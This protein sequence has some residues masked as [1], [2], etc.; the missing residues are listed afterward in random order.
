MKGSRILMPKHTIKVNGELIDCAHNQ[1]ISLL[2]QLEQV[3]YRIPRGCGIGCCGV[4][5]L[6]LNKGQV[7]MDHKG[8]ISDKDIEQGYILPCC[9]Y[10]SEDI[11]ILV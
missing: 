2:S 5:K 9:S 4:C 7:V 3:G 1:G 10:P 6:R 8:G 11:E